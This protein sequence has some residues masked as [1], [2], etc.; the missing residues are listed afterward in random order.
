[1]AD[2]PLTPEERDEYAR[3]VGA[4]LFTA[5]QANVQ[6]QKEDEARFDKFHV[7]NKM[8][9]PVPKELLAEKTGEAGIFEESFSN[10]AVPATTLQKVL[11]GYNDKKLEF[12]SQTHGALDQEL[13]AAEQEYAHMLSKVRSK[14]AEETPYVDAFITGLLSDK[15]AEDNES[16]G[17]LMDLLKKLI[18]FSLSPAKPLATSAVTAALGSSA[19]AA[20][21]TKSYLD[22][23]R[24]G[25]DKLDR[26]SQETVE[27]VPV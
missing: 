25:R 3:N 8:M 26:L 19:A 24:E 9:V 20:A 23:K 21:L 12:L 15:L 2:R 6:K 5:I 22:S 14:T 16:E 4:A 13:A 18:P 11:K 17:A 10:V 1:M 7:G 27:L